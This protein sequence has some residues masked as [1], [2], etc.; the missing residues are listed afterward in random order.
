MRGTVSHAVLTNKLK[1]QLDVGDIRIDQTLFAKDHL[2][3]RYSISNSHETDPNAFPLLG[4]FPLR[5]RGQNVVL[6][7]THIFSPKWLA[8]SQFSYYRSVFFFTSSLQGQDIN[9][10]AGIQ[11]VEGNAA[12]R[13]ALHADHQQRPGEYG[14]WLATPE[15]HGNSARYLLLS[16]YGGLLLFFTVLQG[17]KRNH[18]LDTE[19]LAVFETD[20]ATPCYLYLHNGEVAQALILG[21][22]GSGKSFLCNFLLTN[23]QEYKPLT[24]IFDISGSY[25]NVGQESRGSRMN[26]FSLEPTKENMQF[27]FSYFRVLIVGTGQRYKLDFKEE[28]KLGAAIENMYVVEPEQRSLSTFVEI[29]GEL[30]E[31]LHRWTQDE[32]Y[33]FLFDNAEDTLTFSNFQTFNFGG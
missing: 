9:T 19:H 8:E 18:H 14:P 22:T 17:E 33:G 28:S 2:M 5:S 26:L 29:I 3:G 7:E 25:L 21:M 4:G 20:N 11:G 1:Q 6:R 13:P 27:L 10:A 23:A 24:Y 31:R 15:R 32:Q 12:V 30:K 16:N